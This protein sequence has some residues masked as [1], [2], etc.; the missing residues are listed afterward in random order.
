MMAQTWSSLGKCAGNKFRNFVRQ[1]VAD[2]LDKFL[3]GYLSVN[4]K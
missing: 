3:N 4:P 2:Q 1:T